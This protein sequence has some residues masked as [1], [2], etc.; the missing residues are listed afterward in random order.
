MYNAEQK[1]AFAAATYPNE[2]KQA[3]I[4]GLFELFAPYEEA[5]GRDLV[6]QPIEKLQPAFN[7]ISKKLTVTKAKALLTALQKYRKWYLAD[8]P[9]AV[10]AGVLLLKVDV[11]DK[12]RGSMV[13]SLLHLKMALDEVFDAPERESLD[14][15]YRALLWMAFVGVPRDQAMLVTVGEV[16]FYNMQIHHGGQDYPISPEGLAEFHKLCELDNLA[17]IH[18]NPYYE[19]RRPRRAGD[20][21]LRGYGPQS[22]LVEKV[23][24]DMSKR[25]SES[26]WALTYDS[27]ATSGL[28]H[29]KFELERCGQAVSF[30]EFESN[31][32]SRNRKNG[33]RQWKA[34]FHV[35]K[36]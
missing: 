23:C 2:A 16:D 27:V 24:S 31:K 22:I 6:Q 29:G 19:Q 9:N 33:Y 21:L 17:Y 34:L 11:T 36:E 1:A 8:K 14:C 15:V 12:L 5:W 28:F 35:E 4:A 32:V 18:Q 25:F 20:Q 7:E 13:A 10:C 30:Q 3:E 26:K